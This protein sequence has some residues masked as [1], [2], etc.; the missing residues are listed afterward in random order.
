MTILWNGGREDDEGGRE[1][2]RK[3]GREGGEVG[4]LPPRW[5]GTARKEGGF[6][7]GQRNHRPV[8]IGKFQGCSVLPCPGRWP[9][10]IDAYQSTCFFVF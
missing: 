7:T 2:E 9:P 1:G 5:W 6:L 10:K 3:G 8:I 4:R